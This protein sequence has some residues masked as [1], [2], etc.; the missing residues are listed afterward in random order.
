[1][2]LN[3][4]FNCYFRVGFWNFGIP[5]LTEEIPHRWT[6]LKTRISEVKGL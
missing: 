6:W 4:D 5:T 2:H 3:D 1:M